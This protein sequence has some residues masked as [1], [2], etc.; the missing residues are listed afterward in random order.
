M[1]RDR[2]LDLFS[3]CSRKPLRR[4]E[5]VQNPFFR[6]TGTIAVWLQTYKE[7]NILKSDIIFEH[8]F[9]EKFENRIEKEFFLFG[10]RSYAE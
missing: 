4:K 5:P 10:T 9:D 8:L 6:C 1:D 2:K 3:C 7:L